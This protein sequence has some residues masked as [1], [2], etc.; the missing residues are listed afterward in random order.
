MA[1]ARVRLHGPAFGRAVRCGPRP[2][3]ERPSR[4]NIHNAA[5]AVANHVRHNFARQQINSLERHIERKVPFVLGKSDNV[6]A[7][8]DAGAVAENVDLARALDYGLN[9][10]PAFGGAADIA[11]QENRLR[12]RGLRFRQRSRVLSMSSISSSATNAPISASRS[13]MPRPMPE[14]APVTIATLPSSDRSWAAR[15]SIFLDC[16]F[17]GFGRGQ[18]V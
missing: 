5:A 7:N 3:L 6:F 4:T 12:L 10:A 15:S 8:G 16:I 2:S 1:I 11:V 17:I 18:L 9:S 13:E 14:A